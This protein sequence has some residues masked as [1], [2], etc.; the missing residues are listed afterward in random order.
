MTPQKG[1]RFSLVPTRAA[2]ESENF[3]EC[4]LLF[5]CNSDC[6][7]WGRIAAHVLKQEDNFKLRSLVVHEHFNPVRRL[8]DIS[9]LALFLRHEN[10]FLKY[11]MESFKKLFL[12][13]NINFDIQQLKY[14]GSCPIFIG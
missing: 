11:L 3:R 12:T 5:P 10:A 4:F 14:T 1:K 13:F 9:E 8:K 2:C 7:V 6:E